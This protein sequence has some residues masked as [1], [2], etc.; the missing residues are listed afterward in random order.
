MPHVLVRHRVNDYEVWRLGF[1]AAL[2]VRKAAGEV[3]FQL[4]N[5]SDNS[6]LVV[7][8]FEWESLEKAKT[9]FE[10]APLKEAMVAAGV[11]GEPDI[12]YLTST[13]PA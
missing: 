4:F 13:P 2:E 3:S 7:G 1:D 11:V 6:L 8:L 10:G 12:H 9:F 5:G